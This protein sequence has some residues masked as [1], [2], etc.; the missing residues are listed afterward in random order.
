MELRSHCRES[1]LGKFYQIE[2][3]NTNITRITSVSVESSRGGEGE[4]WKILLFLGPDMTED[5]AV[6]G[7]FWRLYSLTFK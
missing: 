5:W 1:R 7:V 2:V 6:G 3:K 4:L